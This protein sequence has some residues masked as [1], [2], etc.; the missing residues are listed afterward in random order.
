MGQDLV[1]SSAAAAEIFASVDAA[2]GEPLSTIL[3]EGPAERLTLT[4]NAQPGIL[5]VSCAIL[6]AIRERIPTLPLPRLVAGHSLGEYSALVAARAL[7]LEDA[8]R[9]VR[10]R[11]VAMQSAVASGVGAMSAIMGIDRQGVEAICNEA[12]QGEVVAPANFNAPGQI[13]IAGH[14][15]AVARAGALAAA[16]QGRAKP[17]NV[18]APFHC[19]LMAPAATALGS[20]L[21]DVRVAP[22]I[23]PIVAN[24]DAQANGD[25]NRVKELLVKQVDGAVRWEESVRL[26]HTMG[27]THALEIGPG[28][29]LAGLV[30]RITKEIT[31]LSVGDLAS[32]DLVPSFLSA[33][34]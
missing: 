13:V 10:A 34:G 33:A 16:R 2:L 18:S 11:G 5:A 27:I 29:V 9:L 24:F 6:A 31:V 30:K 3:F 15:A 8:V 17:L 19:A 23:C 1:G 7:S 20:E 14:A 28:K 12:S 22:P 25:A 32:L 4:A 26:M 21:A